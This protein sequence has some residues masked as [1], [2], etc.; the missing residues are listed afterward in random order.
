MTKNSNCFN[1]VRI[2]NL[3][4]SYWKVMRTFGDNIES[5]RNHAT[6]MI[7]KYL[8]IYGGINH[9]LKY[10]SDMYVLDVEIGKWLNL[11]IQDFKI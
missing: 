1:D 4:S 5:R 3:D 8:F 10:L 7:G 11:D 9:Q 2:F 6:C